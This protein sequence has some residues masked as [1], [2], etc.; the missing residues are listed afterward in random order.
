[1]ESQEEVEESLSPFNFDLVE[2]APIEAVREEEE[3]IPK[4]SPVSV[5]TESETIESEAQEQYI[6]NDV[7]VPDM[8]S[9]I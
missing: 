7:T 3:V 4:L 8:K 5:P 6:E 2:Q 1:M 9:S